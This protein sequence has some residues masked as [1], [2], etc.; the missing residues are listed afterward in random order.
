MKTKSFACVGIA[1]ITLALPKGPL[2]AMELPGGQAEIREWLCPPGENELIA[3]HAR[4][5]ADR[6]AIQKVMAD[7]A[8]AVKQADLEAI[9][10]LVTEDA[11]FWTHGA[12]PLVGREAL[13][14][15]FEPHLKTYQLHQKY[16]CKELIISGT[17]AFMRGMEVNQLTPRDG[18]ETIV[19]R[20]RAFSVLQRDAKGLWRFAR[21]MTNLP[22]ER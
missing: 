16:D 20:Q 9:A 12:A 10:S 18:G 14:D 17:W 5:Q 1:A 15:A 13:I 6:N 7:W 8:A 22:P 2:D 21:G 19:R 4:T 3:E 11:E